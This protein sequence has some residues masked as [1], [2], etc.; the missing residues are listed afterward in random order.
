MNKTK[1]KQPPPEQYVT[2]TSVNNYTIKLRFK[3]KLASC[4]GQKS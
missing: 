2:V 3:G 4:S 1:I